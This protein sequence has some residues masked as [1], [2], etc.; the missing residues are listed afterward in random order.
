MTC[1]PIWIK[2]YSSTSMASNKQLISHQFKNNNRRLSTSSPPSQCISSHPQR[3]PCLLQRRRHRSPALPRPRR[4]RRRRPE[5]RRS[6]QARAPKHRSRC[7]YSN[8]PISLPSPVV[9]DERLM[10]DVDDHVQPCREKVAPAAS[11]AA[12]TAPGLRARIRRGPGRR[13]PRRSGGWRRTG[14]PRGRAG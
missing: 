6:P 12:P 4:R 7:V 5:A 10:C 11:M 14:R 3:A 9:V 2:P 1:R 8:N 13:T